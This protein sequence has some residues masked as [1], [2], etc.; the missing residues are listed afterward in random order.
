M[1]TLRP[2]H[3]RR[4]KTIQKPMTDEASSP[5]TEHPER[6]IEVDE[7]AGERA[8]FCPRNP[9]ANVSGGKIVSRRST[10]P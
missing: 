4:R 5:R 3:P 8:T 10:S 6:P 1:T 7:R 9:M 2:I